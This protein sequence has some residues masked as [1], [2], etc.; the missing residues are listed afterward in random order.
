[1]RHVDP[2]DCVLWQGC[3]DR[4]GYGAKWIDGRRVLVHRWAYEQER[5]P[6]PLGLQIDHLCRNRACYKVDHLA[7]VTGPENN[8]RAK[9]R[10]RCKQGHEFS[11]ENTVWQKDGRR[12]CRTCRTEV[13]AR[14]EQRRRERRQ[15]DR[16]HD[17][18]GRDR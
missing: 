14:S 2:T 6:I 10:E 17:T 7:A 15:R 13:Y 11:P 1:M 12:K 5:G 16:G 8:R 3:L 9:W 18:P 4:D